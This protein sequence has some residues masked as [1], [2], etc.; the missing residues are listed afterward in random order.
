M[1]L[2]STDLDWGSWSGCVKPI[3]Y[4]ARFFYRLIRYRRAE[5]DSEALDSHGAVSII[6]QKGA[7]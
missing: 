6:L 4:V 7:G 3:P 1:R 5:L 2:Q